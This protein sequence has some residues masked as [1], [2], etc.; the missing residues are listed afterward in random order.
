MTIAEGVRKLHLRTY[1]TLNRHVKGE[2][3]SASF[4]L[5]PI[6]AIVIM[7]VPRN[8]KAS[9]PVYVKLEFAT[10]SQWSNQ[11]VPPPHAENDP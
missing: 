3:L 10:D 5:G 7:N 9:A 1:C 11:P 8:G 2:T 6:R 4:D